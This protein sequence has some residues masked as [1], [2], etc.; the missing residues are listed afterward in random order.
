MA[1]K[2][3][4]T[5]NGQLIGESGPEGTVDYQLDG[6]GSV[7]GTWRTTGT[8][9]NQY[10]YSGYGQ[11]VHKSGTGADP[12]FLWVGGWGYRTRGM[13]YVRRRTYYEKAAVWTSV[14]PFWPDESAYGYA[15]GN[16][17]TQIDPTGE[18]VAAILCAGACVGAGGCALGVWY[19]C[20]DWEGAYDSWYDCA[21]EFISDLPPQSLIGCG[22][23]L[24][25]CLACLAKYAK[26]LCKQLGN[27]N[28]KER[29][30]WDDL[31][32]RLCHDTAQS[33]DPRN[34]NYPKPPL[35]RAKMCS[36]SGPRL[37]NGSLCLAARVGRHIRCWKNDHNLDGHIKAI[38]DTAKRVGPCL[39]MW[40]KYSC[41]RK[42]W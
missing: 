1:F 15:L 2:S 18:S 10:R 4:Q 26:P 28:E 22:L 16:P 33:C 29:Q 19:A 40:T 36:F 23:S 12:Y 42:P 20:K 31:V 6:L 3:Y 11:L 8:L 41:W 25:G 14:D 17:S 7:I 35:T 13:V 30:W 32:G 37:R 38:I 34:K 24:V 21:Y 39:A 5:M 27:C 9:Q